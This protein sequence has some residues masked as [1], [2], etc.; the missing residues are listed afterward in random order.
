MKKEC[1]QEVIPS[2]FSHILLVFITKSEVYLLSIKWKAIS[3]SIKLCSCDISWTTYP[4]INISLLVSNCHSS[5]PGKAKQ[6]Q[7]W[8]FADQDHQIC[9]GN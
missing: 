3:F 2:L 5:S 9:S 1:L 6:C 8:L 4:M 7:Y